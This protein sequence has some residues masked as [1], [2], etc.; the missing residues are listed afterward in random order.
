MDIDSINAGT[1]DTKGWLNPTV[2]TLRAKKIYCDDI[3]G[4]PTGAPNLGWTRTAAS[5]QTATIVPA[6]PGYTWN[7][8][9]SSTPS[10]SVPLAQFG[11]NAVWEVFYSGSI[12]QLTASGPGSGVRF[13]LSLN[14][15]LPLLESS[16]IAGA[17][18]YVSDGTT[19]TTFEYRGTIRVLSAPSQDL[20]NIVSSATLQTWAVS[21]AVSK[22]WAY[23]SPIDSVSTFRDLATSTVTLAPAV[24][25]FSGGP[26][27]S[28]T[29]DM[30]YARRIA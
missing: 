11:T 25:G 30:A 13:G 19:L 18:A 9:A 23:S 5:G 26:N 8:G 29:V 6:S 2:G 3:E 15:N 22:N 24:C 21:T 14:A 10:G 17:L 1:V 20:T 4:G 16:P 27:F 7:A 12:T 28:V